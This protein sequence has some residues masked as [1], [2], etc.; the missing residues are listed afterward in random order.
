MTE[1][2]SQQDDAFE[3]IKITNSLLKYASRNLNSKNIRSIKM[4][5][6]QNMII[7][8]NEICLDIAN[9]IF[10]HLFF[11]LNVTR[12]Q[13]E[14]D[15][16]HSDINKYS[17]MFTYV[18]FGKILNLSQYK[19]ARFFQRNASTIKRYFDAFTALEN[20]ALSI[21][22][23]YYQNYLTI[24]AKIEHDVEVLQRTYIK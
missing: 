24:L 20:S 10:M 6:Q 13:I 18:L 9:I 21:E 15:N 22:K 17:K 8:R 5:I 1:I 4:E 16:S 19:I 12:Q 23:K 2:T 7:P 3:L 14:Y 11:E